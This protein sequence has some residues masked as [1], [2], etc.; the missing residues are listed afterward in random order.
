MTSEVAAQDARATAGAQAEFGFQLSLQRS[1]IARA[2]LLMK[3]LLVALGLALVRSAA[4]GTVMTGKT[5]YATLLV[6]LVSLVYVGT[7][8]MVT[9]QM[10][11]QQQ[12]LPSWFWYISTFIEVL[13]P[14]SLIC[15]GMIFSSLDDVVATHGP[16]MLLYLV[17]AILSIL[18]LRPVLCIWGGLLAS[19]SHIAL[20]TVAL[21]NTEQVIERGM[22][23]RL[24]SYAVFMLLGWMCAAFV[25]EHVLR[26]ARTGFRNAS[27]PSTM[28]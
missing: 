1:E 6:L 24:Y 10:T 5:L 23:P 12:L 21:S 20:V 18:R 22:Y 28:A 16:S 14:T 25:A 9:R 7:I 27:A 19:G 11:E 2:G 13:I 8:R 4:G 26:H 3:V 17:L 15:V